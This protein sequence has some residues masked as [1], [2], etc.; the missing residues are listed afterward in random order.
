M[1]YSIY[2]KHV[3]K[4]SP[5]PRKG[6]LHSTPLG[7][8]Y[9]ISKNLWIYLQNYFRTLGW[10]VLE[11]VREVDREK[12]CVLLSEVKSIPLFLET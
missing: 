12:L 2:L 4:Y 1:L 5:Q 7:E 11:L 6:T 3:T 9:Q 8:K 10:F